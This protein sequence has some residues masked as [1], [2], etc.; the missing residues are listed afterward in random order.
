MTHSKLINDTSDRFK[1]DQLI[2]KETAETL[3]TKDLATPKFHMLPK[4]HKT[5]ISGR[6][7]V[8]FIGCHSINISKFVEYYLKPIVKNIPSYVQDSNDFLN[9]IDAAK[10]IPAKCLLGTVDV[11]SLYTNI[12]NL[13]GISA[14][15]AAHENYPEKSV[16]AKV[17]ITFLALILTLSKF[18]FNCKNY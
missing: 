6:P 7:A 1:E 17:I 12:P 10:S 15:K 11:K 14:I 4:I 16:A 8:S 3:K 18:M 9:K 2:P 5:D 13:E